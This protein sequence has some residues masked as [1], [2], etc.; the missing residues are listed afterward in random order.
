MD[1]EPMNTIPERVQAGIA[2]LDRN[3]PGWREEINKYVFNIEVCTACI[4][5][6]V[7]GNFWEVVESH[8]PE[9]NL[10]YDEAADLGFA[11]QLRSE[12]DSLQTEWLKQL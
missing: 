12:W 3:K 5:G 6:Q 10:T 9:L 7:F 1:E 11:S 8:T 2:W 4:L